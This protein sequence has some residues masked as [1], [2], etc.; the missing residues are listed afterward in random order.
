MVWKGLETAIETSIY[1]DLSAAKN[2]CYW[3]FKKDNNV[4]AGVLITIHV[5]MSD[6]LK[7]TKFK[8]TIHLIASSF[9]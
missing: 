7:Q 3:P 9:M 5:I 1:Y 4:K 8:S 6:R 2:F